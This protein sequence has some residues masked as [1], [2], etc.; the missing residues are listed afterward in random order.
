MILR[1]FVGEHFT[2]PHGKLLVRAL[3]G[4][5]ITD[6]LVFSTVTRFDFDR[7]IDDKANRIASRDTLRDVRNR[8]LIDVV[9]TTYI[10]TWLE[11]GILALLKNAGYDVQYNEEKIS[12]LYSFDLL[13]TIDGI[14]LRLEIKLQSDL[15]DFPRN[16]FSFNEEDKCTNISQVWNQSDFVIGVMWDS[17]KKIGKPWI[18]IDS[19]AFC[20]ELEFWVPSKI[21]KGMYLQSG[22]A[23]RAGLVQ[24]LTGPKIEL[25]KEAKK[26]SSLVEL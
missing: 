25:P 1:P 22:K 14:E 18:V 7:L 16:T 20:S 23:G 12:D 26:L 5:E 13:V 11:I 8:S 4:T 21:G 15:P 9:N 24:Y 17:Q 2:T 6:D 10:G 19:F 3:T